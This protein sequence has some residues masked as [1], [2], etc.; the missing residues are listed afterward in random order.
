MLLRL[1]RGSC[2][3]LRGLLRGRQLSTVD[4]VAGDAA[5]PAAAVSE[6]TGK[7]PTLG[8]ALPPQVLI[9][10]LRNNIF[11]TVSSQPGHLLFKLNA[12]M[13]GFHGSHKTSSK[14][15]LAMLDVLQQRLA[16]LKIGRIRL[17]FRG[18]N[19][20]RAVMVAQLRRMGLSIA[21]VVD[22]TGVPFNGCRPPKARR[23]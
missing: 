14:A 20:A 23:L 10:C 3:A 4:A 8:K 21:E 17:N 16:A 22:S 18:L 12:G 1:L 2:G 7:P 6:K 13:A 11:I 15:A 5:R 9:N 19:P